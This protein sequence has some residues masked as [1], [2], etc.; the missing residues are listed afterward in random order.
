MINKEREN[1]T[2]ETGKMGHQRDR[3]RGERGTGILRADEF[4]EFEMLL[5]ARSRIAAIKPM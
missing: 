1:Q 3:S 2:K 5:Y 4:D